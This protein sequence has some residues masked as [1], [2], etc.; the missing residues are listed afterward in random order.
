[1]IFKAN[2]N[3][4][5]HIFIYSKLSLANLKYIGWRILNELD[6]R[7]GDGSG[8]KKF[9]QTL[10]ILSPDVGNGSPLPWSKAGKRRDER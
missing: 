3:L 4:S 6:G 7:A 8:G 2:I 5:C 10:V 1:M 9:F